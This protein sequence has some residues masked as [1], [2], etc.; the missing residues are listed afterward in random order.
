MASSLP[1]SPPPAPLSLPSQ[2]SLLFNVNR[3]NTD[4]QKKVAVL[5]EQSSTSYTVATM[6]FTV[7]MV[8]GVVLVS[9]GSMHSCL[10]EIVSGV[11][12]MAVSLVCIALL[13]SMIHL[14]KT[15]PS[16]VQQTITL[17]NNKTSSISSFQLL[18]SAH[19][20]LTCSIIAKEKRIEELKQEEQRLNSRLRHWKDLVHSSS[21]S[22]NHEIIV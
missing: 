7:V 20:K 1:N 14:I 16:K 8:C 21:Q 5:V 18:Q 10:P 17:V 6:L 3:D 11:V 2:C 9:F 12:L 15:L 19:T 4:I 13:I 22:S